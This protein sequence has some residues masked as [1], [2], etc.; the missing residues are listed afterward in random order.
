MKR[1]QLQLQ[2][3]SGTCGLVSCLG[4]KIARQASSEILSAFRGSQVATAQ[5]DCDGWGFLLLCRGASDHEARVFFN[6][7]ESLAFTSIRS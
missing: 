6:E 4:F 2:D 7:N 5:A 1:C 3:C